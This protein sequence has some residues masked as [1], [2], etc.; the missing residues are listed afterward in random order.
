MPS[1]QQSEKVQ[2][3]ARYT[4][5]KSSDENGVRLGRYEKNIVSDRGD[6]YHEYFGGV[7]YYLNNHKLKLQ[8]GVQYAKMADK[9][10]DGGAY[11]GWSLTLALRSYW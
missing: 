7:N 4:Y 1:F 8:A 3:V 11:D 6:Q 9:A 5:L 2:W 10:N